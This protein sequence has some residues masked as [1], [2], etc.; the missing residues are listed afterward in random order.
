MP[1]ELYDED[2]F[3]ALDPIPEL[4]PWSVLS[5]YIEVINL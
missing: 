4:T 2:L 5:M 3:Y 1:K